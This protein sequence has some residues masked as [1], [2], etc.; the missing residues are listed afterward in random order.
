MYFPAPLMPQRVGEADD[1][2]G[3][4]A[5]AVHVRPADRPTTRVAPRVVVACPVDVVSGDRDTG[6][7]HARRR[8]ESGVD[9]ASVAVRTTDRLARQLCSVDVLAVERDAARSPTSA[10]D[11]PVVNAAPIEPRSTERLRSP[12]PAPRGVLFAQ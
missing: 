2:L 4:D 11:Q 3:I 1:E 6:E 12:L 8:D 10:G 9:A 7:G 5:D